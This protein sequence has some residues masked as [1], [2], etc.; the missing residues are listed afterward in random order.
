MRT[1]I[2]QEKNRKQMV[3]H[4]YDITYGVVKPHENLVV[5]DDSIVRGTTLKQSIIKILSKTNP[6]RII[7]VSTAPQIRYPDCYGIDMAS[8]GRFIAFQAG[9]TVARREKGADID[10]KVFE[11]CR[12]ELKKPPA[13][14]KN[15]VKQIFEG[16]CIQEIERQIAEMVRPTEPAWNGELQVI[17]QSIEG[18][19]EA[20]SPNCGDWY[21]T[22]DYPTPWGYAIVNRSYVNFC[23]GDNRRATELE[24]LPVVS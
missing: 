1:F 15:A 19:K 7:I 14:Q 6:K 22:G 4:V 21:F 5:I 9:L 3:S 13:E 8:I 2:S 12:E 10:A 23:K 17:Y 20:I 11:A 16:L 24:L 18:L